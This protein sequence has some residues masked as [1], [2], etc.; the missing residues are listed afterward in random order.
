MGKERGYI[1][2]IPSAAQQKLT[3]PCKAITRQLKNAAFS[4]GFQI[5]GR[6]CAFTA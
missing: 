4:T 2:L 3:Q 5:L 6:T 1:Q